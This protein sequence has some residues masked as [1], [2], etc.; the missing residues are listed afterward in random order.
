MVLDPPAKLPAALTTERNAAALAYLARVGALDL[1]P[2]L[3]LAV[4]V[5][6]VE[7][8]DADQGDRVEGDHPTANRAERMRGA[9]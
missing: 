9:A 7:A 2:M 1:A 5:D 3:G 6:R 4:E 8:A